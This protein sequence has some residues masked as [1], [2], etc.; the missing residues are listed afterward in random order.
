MRREVARRWVAAFVLLCGCGAPQYRFPLRSPMWVDDDR[1]AFVGRPT[2]IDTPAQWDRIDHTMF[3]QLS[4]LW[5]YEREHEAVN[6]NSMDEVPNSSWFTNRIGLSPMS[7]ERLARGACVAATAPPRPWTVTRAKTS[8][9]SP[10]LFIRDAAGNSFLFKV[11]FDLPERGTAADSIASRIF[12]AVGYETPC[13]RVVFLEREELLLAE[14]GDGPSLDDVN[15]LLERAVRLEDGRIRGSLSELVVGEPIGGWL[16]EGLRED[17]PNDVVPHQDRR[18]VRGMYVLSA[19]LNHIDTRAE[20]NLDTWVERP[21]GRG[22]V[23]HYVLDAGDSFGQLFPQ[24]IVMTQSFGLSHYV[25]FQH[26]IEDFLTLGI[27]DRGWYGVERGPAGDVLGYYDVERFDPNDWRNGYPNP[28]FERAS[29]RDKAWMARILARFSPEHLRA[30]VGT[31]QFSRQTTSDE[32]VRI[33]RGRQGRLL[34]RY[35]TRLSP[36]S[37]PR[38]R[39]RELC[40]RDVALEAGFRTERRYEAVAYPGW[41]TE[42]LITLEARRDETRA[43]VTLPDAPEEAYWV[44]DLIAQTPGRE[45][46]GPARVHLYAIDGGYRVVGLERPEP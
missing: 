14:G 10:G 33:L 44:V 3:R 19:W 18:E 36:L 25:D 43:C 35:L 4:E 23:Q 38:A 28:A 1:R 37:F 42:R 24:S 41:P 11:D 16:F 5:L 8:G 20:N 27:A 21:D 6:V 13:N 7:P 31:A 30:V 22:Y 34:E 9:T 12:W 17:D 45:R 29:E 32:L 40:L 15:S 2:E 39:G 26:M 46:T